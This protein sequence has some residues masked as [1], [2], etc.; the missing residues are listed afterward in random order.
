MFVTVSWFGSDLR[1]W[2]SACNTSL[3]SVNSSG[4]RIHTWKSD[5]DNISYRKLHKWKSRLWQNSVNETPWSWTR[6]GTWLYFIQ[7]ASYLK[8]NLTM[9]K[10]HTWNFMKFNL[11]RKKVHVF[12]MILTGLYHRPELYQSMSE[13][14]HPPFSRRP[15]HLP[16]PSGGWGC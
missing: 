9:P 3:F 16:S 15:S 11:I 7:E 6:S 10:F 1:M 5:N 4:V 12:W 8:K 13:S 2:V 14:G